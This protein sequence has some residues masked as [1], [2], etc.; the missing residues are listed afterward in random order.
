MP[1]F[2]GTDEIIVPSIFE[3]EVVAALVRRGARRHLVDR[4]FEEHFAARSTVTIGPRAVRSARTVVELTNMRAADALYVWL[5]AREGLPLVTL[6]REV[7][8]RAPLAG[9]TA[10]LP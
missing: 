7:I 9:V 10:M 4:F 5:A 6:D 8:L 3:L 2:F 1:L